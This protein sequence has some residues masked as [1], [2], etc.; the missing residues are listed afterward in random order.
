LIDLKGRRG[1]IWECSEQ[2]ST[3]GHDVQDKSIRRS[4]VAAAVALA[5]MAFGA[6]AHQPGTGPGMMQGGAPTGP[7]MM[8]GRAPMGPGMTQGGAPMGPGMMQGGAPM[9]PGMMQGR[10]S[11]GPGMM[12][13][14]AP[15]GPGMMH[16]SGMMG[17]DSETMAAHHQ[18]MHAGGRDELHRG[19]GLLGLEGRRVVPM[20]R[21]SA[22]DVRLWLEAYLERTG[23][24]RLKVGSVEAADERTVR[25][26]IVTV[27]DSLVE[28]LAV[29]RLTGRITSGG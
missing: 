28:S 3:G 15:T 18:A 20:V 17:A 14:G 10:A 23:N 26:E 12:Q 6:N 25:A 7:G 1:F 8:Q 13:G 11:A 29:D 24:P 4:G 5:I 27:D 2:S 21:L 19:G 16:G 22:A 9:G